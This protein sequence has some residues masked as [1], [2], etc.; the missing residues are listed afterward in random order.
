MTLEQRKKIDDL[1]QT[2]AKLSSIKE[3]QKFKLSTLKDDLQINASTTM[4]HK[5]RLN[6]Q[7]NAVTDDLQSTKIALQEISAREKQ[8]R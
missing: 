1:M 2:C 3:K 7:L 6:S 8:V 5:D 4:E